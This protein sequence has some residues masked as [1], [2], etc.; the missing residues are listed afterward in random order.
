MEIKKLS[1]NELEIALEMVWKV[2][3]EYEAVDYPEGGKKAF[4]Q[5]IHSEEYLATL[6]AYGALCDEKIVGIM[7]TRNKGT[8]VALFFVDGKYHRKGIGKK[9]WEAVLSNTS[10]NMITVH[11]SLYAAEIYKKLGFYQTDSI[12]EDGGIQ[13]IP[14]EYNVLQKAKED[15][16]SALA[17]PWTLHDRI[18]LSRLICAKDK[19]KLE[20]IDQIRIA[21]YIDDYAFLDGNM[22][23][24]DADVC[25]LADL[26]IKIMEI[27]QETIE[28]LCEDGNFDELKKFVSNALYGYTSDGIDAICSILMSTSDS[29]YKHNFKIESGNGLW[30]KTV[31]Q[32]DDGITIRISKTDEGKICKAYY[33][34]GKHFLTIMKTGKGIGEEIYFDSNENEVSRKSIELDLA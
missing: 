14:M 16:I 31:I 23:W 15:I 7:A 21:H 30:G 9:L 1:K 33:N 26:L 11:S 10:A 25:K 20:E 17:Q 3:C 18:G 5:A 22:I 4:Y 19:L 34:E 27:P 28:V 32:N 24:K 6:E 13:Y 29:D 12:K 2:F 8:H